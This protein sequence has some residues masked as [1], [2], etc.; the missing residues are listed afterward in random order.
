MRTSANAGYML[1]ATVLDVHTGYRG[2]FSG[3][4][5]RRRS[6]WAKHP[7]V[8]AAR[9]GAAASPTLGPRGISVQCDYQISAPGQGNGSCL[10]PDGARH[11]MHF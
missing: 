11:Q 10:F 6:A 3:R 2:T 1:V 4:G 9:R 5:Y 8:S 7:C